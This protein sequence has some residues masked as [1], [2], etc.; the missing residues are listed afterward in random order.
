M[1]SREASRTPCTSSIPQGSVRPESELRDWARALECEGPVQA[2][3]R[4]GHD[5]VVIDLARSGALVETSRRLTPGASAELQREVLDG[6]HA[7]RASV[8]RSH[9]CVLLRDLVL[10]RTALA[11]EQPVPRLREEALAGVG[12]GPV[13]Q[14]TGGS[15]M[16]SC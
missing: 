15:K 13:R 3:I 11:F 8:V 9:V 1:T 6:G 16:W 7:T 2:R 14:G 5:V 12:P 10:F 4:P